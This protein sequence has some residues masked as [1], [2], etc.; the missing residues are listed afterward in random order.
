MIVD[1]FVAW[2]YSSSLVELSLNAP[3][4]VKILQNTFDYVCV[5]V[6]HPQMIVCASC[7][8]WCPVIFLSVF[9]LSSKKVPDNHFF[10]KCLKCKL[11]Y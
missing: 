3:R 8:L 7:E 10:K 5:A 2:C 1:D 6:V 11:Q 9:V 4:L